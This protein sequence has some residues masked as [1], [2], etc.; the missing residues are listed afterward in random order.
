[1]PLS[2]R[3]S[4]HGKCCLL[5]F[6]VGRAYEMTLIKECIERRALWISG[7][8]LVTAIRRM[9]LAILLASLLT[10]A[11]VTATFAKCNPGRANDGIHYWDGGVE[12]PGS[13]VGGVYSDLYTYSPWVNYG[14]SYA[15]V[16]LDNR[17]QNNQWVQV[18]NYEAPGN[19][20]WDLVQYATPYLGPVNVYFNPQTIGTY[21]YQ[22]VLY[23][24]STNVFS[25]QI[26]GSTVWTTNQI[27][28]WQ[29]NEAQ[30]DAEITTLDDQMMGA[31][32]NKQV[33]SNNNIY[34]S[35]SWRTYQPS[36]LGPTANYFY[37]T[38]NGASF[39]VWDGACSQ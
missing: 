14:F 32:N 8:D 30:V 5:A 2:D 11:S 27:T 6:R 1:M 10:G 24:Q 28:S 33:F 7:R 37:L 29:P 12:T 23:N 16:M 3:L 19:V 26:A 15:W 39:N 4:D 21:V 20:R 38:G 18:G 36:S 17:S 25:V 35:G 9:V 22:K 13:V 31:I 34:Y